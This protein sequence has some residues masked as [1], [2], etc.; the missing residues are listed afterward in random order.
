M[1]TIEII[2]E[3]YGEK[4]RAR[5]FESKYMNNK[6][7]YVGVL[8]WDEECQYWESWGDLTVNLPGTTSLDEREAFLDTNNCSKDLIVQLKKA[9]YI[10]ETGITRKSGFCTYPLVEFSEEFMK[11]L[12]NRDGS[13]IE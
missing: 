9:G 1:K 8:T 12:C 11:G 7:L 4:H 6:T 10:K 3:A 13:E 2:F 5:F